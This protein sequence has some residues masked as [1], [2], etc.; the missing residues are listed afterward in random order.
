LS[1]P[2]NQ[3]KQQEINGKHINESRCDPIH[4][5]F[6]KLPNPQQN[7]CEPTHETNTF[8]WPDEKEYR[9]PS[10]CEHRQDEAV[11]CK[12]T[13][14]YYDFPRADFGSGD[15]QTQ[16]NH[17]KEQKN[18]RQIIC[19]GEEITVSNGGNLE[20]SDTPRNPG[21]HRKQEIQTEEK[22]PEK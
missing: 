20:E 18:A 21:C 10:I 12:K 8:G 19:D 7:N 4:T 13:A 15:T 17:A 6:E 22:K 9:H 14:P 2:R 11:H 5:L 3:K 1:D 16:V